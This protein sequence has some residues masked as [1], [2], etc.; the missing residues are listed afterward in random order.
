MQIHYLKIEN[1]TKVSAILNL[2]NFAYFCHMI[3]PLEKIQ[4]AFRH[5]R[6]IKK[7]P[8]RLEF[9]VT[10]YCNLNCRGCTHYSPLAAREFASLEQLEQSMSRLSSICDDKVKNVYLIGG[11]TLLYPRL[12]EAM[13][14][15]RKYFCSQRLFIFTNGIALPKMDDNFYNTAKKLGFVIAVTRYPIKFDY[16]KVIEDV[17][18]RGV[19][20]EVYGDRSMTDSFFRFALDPKGKQNGL[21]SHFKC[22]NRGCMSIVGDKLFPCSIS[23]CVG[24]LNKA[25]NTDF[26]HL[27]GDYLHIPSIKSYSQIQRLR[28]R[29]VPFCRYCIYPVDEVRYCPSKRLKEEWVEE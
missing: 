25:C 26:R 12:T 1:I 27:E 9:V 2:R 8:M 11:E 16:D 15:L 22:F 17:R 7:M 21:I 14:A 13:E 24:H 20:V 29:P 18:A 6:T 4:K 19:E 3:N 10:D 23:A 28:D 5:Y